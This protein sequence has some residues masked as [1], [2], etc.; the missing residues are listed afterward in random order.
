MNKHE[1]INELSKELNYE[2]EKCIIINDIL[3]KNFFI[4]RKNK[5]K[6]VS[7]LVLKLNI[8]LD[9]A[10]RIYE[11]SISIIT[12]QIKDKIKHPFKNNN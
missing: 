4:S 1:F 7:E 12:K 10:N 5:D 3:E 9:E 11:I 8:D 2:E 6:I